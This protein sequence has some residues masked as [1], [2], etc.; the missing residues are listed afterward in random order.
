MT[1]TKW[2]KITVPTP[3]KGQEVCDFCSSPNPPWL[4]HALDGNVVINIINGEVVTDAEGGGLGLGSIG[5]WRACTECS[6]L[7][8]RGDKIGLLLRS[9]AAFSFLDVPEHI[10]RSCMA[11]IHAM[12]W[13]GRYG[14]RVSSNDYIEEEI[15]HD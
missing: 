7:I 5:G 6:E 1:R 14:E 3:P 15:G 2:G 4:Y 13:N 9:I 10:S 8:E 12:F 11:E